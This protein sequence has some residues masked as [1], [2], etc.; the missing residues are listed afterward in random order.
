[1]PVVLQTCIQCGCTQE[2]D[3]LLVATIIS[4]SCGSC[5]A[6]IKYV[7][8]SRMPPAELIRAN[9]WEVAEADVS[10]IN[11][12]KMVINFRKFNRPLYNKIEYYRLYK[13]LLQ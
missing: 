10:R 11:A 9:I 1:M 13:F 2:P 3:L 12:A 4:V 6:H 7:S 5:R 8:A